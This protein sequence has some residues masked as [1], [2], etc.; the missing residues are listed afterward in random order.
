MALVQAQIAV[1]VDSV[2]PRDR[3]IS[4]LHFNHHTIPLVGT[5]DWDTLGSDLANI[6]NSNWGRGALGAQELWVTLYNLDDPQPRAPKSQQVWGK[7]NA[8]A[9]SCPREVALCLSFYADRNQPRR[10]GRMYLSPAARGLTGLGPRPTVSQQNDV[11]TIA[12]ALSG[13]G[14]ADVDWC[15]R[16]IADGDFK[17]VTHAWVDDEWDTQRRRGLRATSRVERDVS[18]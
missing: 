10:R 3:I 18:G 13:L 8:P 17:K 14:G 9:A 5:T 7:G 1:A 6:Y 12:D 15:V 4:V 16:S 11:L 2:L